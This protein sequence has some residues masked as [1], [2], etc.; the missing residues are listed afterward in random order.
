MTTMIKRGREAVLRACNTVQCPLKFH[1]KWNFLPCPVPFSTDTTHRILAENR[2]C[3]HKS[4]CSNAWPILILIM[5]VVQLLK[6]KQ[7]ATH[8]SILAWRILWAKEPEGLWFMGSQRVGHNR[9]TS[10]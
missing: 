8:S 5:V 4:N 10:C 1:R 2:Y 7:M 6:E 9:V 3:K